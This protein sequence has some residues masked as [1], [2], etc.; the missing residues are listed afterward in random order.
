MLALKHTRATA[1]AALF[2]VALNVFWSLISDGVMP[3]HDSAQDAQSALHGEH[4]ATD[5]DAP[6]GG[7]G[8][9]NCAF[10]TLIGD[11]APTV[12]PDAAWNAIVL[13]VEAP[14]FALYVE[15]P[16]GSLLYPAAYSRAPPVVS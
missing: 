13:T 15:P 5:G 8:A 16:R 11:K 1:W 10:C 9:P 2:A 4:C 14:A 6:N 12:F 3:S 7:H